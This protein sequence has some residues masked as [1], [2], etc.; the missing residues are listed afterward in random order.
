MTSTWRTALTLAILGWVAFF[1]STVHAQYLLEVKLNKQNFLTFEGVEATVTIT[2]H[3]GSDIVMGGPAGGNWLT[4]QIFDPS[5]REVPPVRMRSDESIVF[6]SGT[7]LS[8][9]VVLSDSYSFSEYGAYSIA[10]S[11]YYPPSQQYY[12]SGKV[13]ANFSDAKPFTELQFGVPPGLPGAGDVHLYSLAI[14]HDTDAVPERTYLYLRIVD[15]KTKT[16]LFTFS[17]GTIIQV[18]DPQ[19]TL[20]RQNK[21][22]ILFM[23]A[24]HIY[25]YLC[26]DTQG[27]IAKRLYYK[28]ME[29]DRPHLAVADGDQVVVQGGLPFDPYAP[30]PKTVGRSVSKRPPGF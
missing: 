10:A 11:V 3:S 9:T 30:V 8:R 12:I 13:R 24:P 21:L 22:N 29:S 17:L 15:E 1:S 6:K 28:E 7:N 19:M 18:A 16:K 23:T 4:F 26:I 2:N 20:D 14:K 25:A 27:Q 5:G